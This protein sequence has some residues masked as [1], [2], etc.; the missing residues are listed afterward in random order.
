MTAIRVIFSIVAAE[1]LHLEQLDVKIA[2]LHGDLEEEIFMAQPKG[3]EVQGKEN[4][5][6]KLHK[7]LYGLKQALRQWYKKFNEFMRNSGFHRC[8]EDHCCYVKKYVDSYIILALYVDD[9][10]IAGANMAEIDRL[11]KQLS[12]NFE[13]KDLGPAKQILGMRISRDRSKGILN[14]SQ[15]KY[16]EKL[17]S[18]FNVGNAKTR[19]TPLG[20]HLKFSKRQSS[21]TEEEENHMSKVPYASAVGSLMYAMVCTR[22]D[23]AHAVGVVS[24]FLSNPG[25][26]HW[27]GV[28]WILRYLKGTSKMHLSFKRSNLTLQGFSDADLGGDLDGRKSTTGYIFTLGGTAISWKSKL[29]GRVSLSTTEAEYIAISETAKEMIWLKN[30]L[31]ELGKGQDEPSL[32]SDSQS[33]I[34]LARNPILHSRCKHIELKYHFIRNLINDGDLI[35]LKISGAENPADM[36][37]KTVTTTKLRLCIASTGLREN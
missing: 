12:E 19:N 37:T 31:K 11:K 24:R 15:E 27:E 35:L 34:C 13:M 5:V 21:Q 30:L 26:E 9:M 22:P 32:F 17:L 28:K 29:Q 2:F 7:S 1:N 18:R 25:K 8:E 6:C 16:I 14:L 3:F 23:I 4:L 20:T 33:A 10:L 36:L